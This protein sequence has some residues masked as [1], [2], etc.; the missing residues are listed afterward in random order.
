[1]AGTRVRR[2]YRTAGVA[3]GPSHAAAAPEAPP[4][5]AEL[6]QVDREYR[7]EAKAGHLQTIA[8]KRFNPDGVAWLPIFHTTR[9]GR[10]YT[11]LFSNT[12]QAHRLRRTRDW[13]VL[14]YR[15]GEGEG[16]ATVVTEY[17]GPLSGRRVVRGREGECLAHYDVHPPADPVGD[18]D[19][20]GVI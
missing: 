3:G 12:G 15:N 14:Y 18:T 2:R 5:V 19:G 6:L 11:A 17:Q 4:P 13:V 20:N 16:Q 1:V 10:R 7:R 8:P 9:G